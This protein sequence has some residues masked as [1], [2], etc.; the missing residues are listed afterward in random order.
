MDSL[1]VKLRS[2]PGLRLGGLGLSWLCS[3]S[4]AWSSSSRGSVLLA[5]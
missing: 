4:S 3:V 2:E 5:Y 1:A